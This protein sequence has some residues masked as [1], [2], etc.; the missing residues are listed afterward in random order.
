MVNLSCVRI[1]SRE[2]V[3]MFSMKNQDKAYIAGFLDADG[4][5]YAQLKR[6]VTYRYKFQI[7]VQVV[8]FQS[9]KEKTFMEELCKAIGRGYIRERKDGIIEYIIG[10]SNSIVWLLSQLIPYLRLKRR[11]AQ[12][13]MEIIE[14]RNSVKNGSDF[15]QLAKRIDEFRDLN[16]SKKRSNTSQ[17][18]RQVLCEEGL[19]TP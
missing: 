1:I 8:F 3:I 5:I 11:Q 13:M 14:Q 7:S 4:S 9:K 15:L 17:V 12:L 6:N 18:V 19:L 10:D 2:V 16:Y